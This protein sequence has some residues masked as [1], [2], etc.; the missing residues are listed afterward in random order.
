MLPFDGPEVSEKGL[1]DGC[2]QHGVAVFVAL[3]SSDYDLVPREVD[4]L[5][6]EA[7]AF[8]QPQSCPVEKHRHQPRRALQAAQEPLDFLFGQDDGQP[9]WSLGANDPLDQANLLLEDLVMQKQQGIQRLVLR[10]G[11]HMGVGG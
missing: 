9:P 11:S 10:R 4:I 2:G 3:A 7:A 5:D 8:H 1:F 6:A